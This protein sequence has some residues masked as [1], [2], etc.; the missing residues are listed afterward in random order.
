MKSVRKKAVKIRVIVILWISL[1]LGQAAAAAGLKGRIDGVVKG[2]PK[3]AFSIHIV[4][5]DSGRTV[6]AHH[7][8]RATIPASNMKIITSAAALHYLGPKFEYVTKVGLVGDTLV[9]I[10]SG[11]P[12]LGDRELDGKAG[13]APGWI[14]A[15]IEA[16]LHQ[17][18]RTRINDL[19][20]DSTI[21]DDQR[22]HP[23]WPLDE[24][25]RA[26]SAEVCGINYNG[27]C[28]RMTTRNIYGRVAIDIEP[29]TVFVKISNQ[30][31]PIGSGK[32]AVGAYRKPGSPNELVVRGKC[33]KQQGPFDVAIEQP[34]VFFGYVLAEQLGAGGIAV[35][36]ELIERGLPVDVRFRRLA[37]Y[38]TALSVCLQ[39]CNKDS[40]NLAAEALLKTVAAHGNLPPAHGSWAL[41]QK[42][43]QDYLSKLGVANSEYHIDDASGLSRDNRLSANTLTTVIGSIYRSRNW[44][45]YRESLAVSGRDGTL[46]M[47]FKDPKYQGKITGKS[48]YL[49]GVRSFS[50]VA[51][52][53]SGDYI[54]SIL[55]NQAYG[56]KQIVYQM[57]KTIIDC[58]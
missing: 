1:M 19:V 25:N 38:R 40:F 26:Y 44:D 57:A 28:I 49:T 43:V 54:F 29:K 23:S 16:R 21:F 53:D 37:E 51:R 24:L 33:R 20:I 14:M 50:G 11:D 56:V 36:G 41:G 52:T 31:R 9:V 6:Y 32:G 47:D 12:L 35:G 45:F 5:A 34:A 4:K 58:N 3:A 48:G 13:R 2:L 8:H 22:V 39:R 42:K 15:D 18:G 7:A 46:D 27:N 17:A 55:A 10:G 30:V